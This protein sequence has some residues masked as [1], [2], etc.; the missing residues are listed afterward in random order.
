MSTEQEQSADRQV[1]RDKLAKV[2]CE[3]DGRAWDVVTR[4]ARDHYRTLAQA[5]LDHLSVPEKEAA[6]D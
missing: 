3:A 2:L 1:R 4:V 5:A 6:D